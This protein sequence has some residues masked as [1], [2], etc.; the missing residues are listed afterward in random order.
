M[1]I[2]LGFTEKMF[3]E[4]I[5]TTVFN[6]LI[7]KCFFF[8]ILRLSFLCK[9]IKTLT[10]NFAQNNF[11]LKRRFLAYYNTTQYCP[12]HPSDRSPIVLY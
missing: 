6:L 9:Y 12:I 11:F 1:I 10:V 8:T 5:P 2:G 7:I 4:I 3:L